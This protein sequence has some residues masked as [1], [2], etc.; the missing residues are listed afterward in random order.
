MSPKTSKKRDDPVTKLERIKKALADYYMSLEV[1][2][3]DETAID[4]I[5][6]QLSLARECIGKV[7]DI[8]HFYAPKSLPSHDL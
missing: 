1:L 3:H 6:Y 4:D 8:V 5:G 7:D 2:I